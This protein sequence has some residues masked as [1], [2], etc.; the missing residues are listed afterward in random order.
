MSRPSRTI[1]FVA[2]EDSKVRRAAV[3]S[4]RPLQR[5]ADASPSQIYYG[6]PIQSGDIGLLY[7][8]KSSL[9]AHTLSASPISPTCVVTSTVRT[10]AR[11]LSPL[12]GDEIK[13]IRGMGYQFGAPGTKPAKPEA[14][15]FFYKPTTSLSGPED[16]IFIPESARNRKNVY[17]GELCVVM[18]KTAL[19]VPVERAMEFVLGYCSS[20]DVSTPTE[21]FTNFDAR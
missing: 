19:N 11:L 7:H 8:A 1:R 4:W 6:Q 2:K 13:T 14:V 12:S 15:G 16:P 21:I 5:G 10:V 3:P 18:G 20:N 9:T 17:E